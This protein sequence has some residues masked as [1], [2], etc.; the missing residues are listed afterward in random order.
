MKRIDQWLCDCGRQYTRPI[1]ADRCPATHSEAMARSAGMDVVIRHGSPRVGDMGGYSSE[2][3]VLIT[4]DQARGTAYTFLIE[5][6]DQTRQWYR[7]VQD[8]TQCERCGRLTDDVTQTKC[9]SCGK[10]TPR[11]PY[12]KNNNA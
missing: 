8:V 9:G 7:Y 3:A 6:K 11:K 12:F 2:P 10:P 4:E 5:R 1:D